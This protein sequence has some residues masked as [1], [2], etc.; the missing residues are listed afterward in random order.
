MP[1]PQTV[2]QTPKLSSILVVCF[3]GAFN[4]VQTNQSPEIY[5]DECE[6][7]KMN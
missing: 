2:S 3:N 6:G 1:T 5:R 4:I 7:E